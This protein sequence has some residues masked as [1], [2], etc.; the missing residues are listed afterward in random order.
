MKIA[1]INKL[2]KHHLHPKLE[3]YHV[4]RDFIYKVQDN[5]FLKGYAF[6]STGNGEYDLAVWCFIQPLFVK[7]DCL[8]FNFGDRLKHK[9]KVDVLRT[10]KLEWW[11]ATKEKLDDSFQSILKSILNDGEKYLNLFKTPEDFYNKFKSDRKE[12][13]RKYEA[14]TYTT[15]LL[16]N[17][18]LQNKMLKGLIEFSLKKINRD[19]EIIDEIREDATLLLNADTK[20]KRLEILKNWANETLRHLKLPDMPQLL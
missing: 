16:N 15:I 20:E 6:E 19:D 9:K 3:N 11:D 1:E 8:Y 2:I 7:S 12:D 10:K 5:F 17:E 4:N 14:V 13:I 18:A